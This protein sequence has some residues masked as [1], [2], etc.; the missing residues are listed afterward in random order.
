MNRR[1]SHRSQL[2]SWWKRAKSTFQQSPN[3]FNV[4]RNFDSIFLNCSKKKQRLIFWLRK[5]QC[6]PHSN[7]K[8]FFSVGLSFLVFFINSFEPFTTLLCHPLHRSTHWGTDNLWTNDFYA[9]FFTVIRAETEKAHM[10]IEGV[11]IALNNKLVSTF[12]RCLWSKFKRYRK[13]SAIGKNYIQDWC[14][15]KTK[16]SEKSSREPGFNT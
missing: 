14:V 8:N 4:S 9:S 15:C 7:K 13:V 5:A 3:Y 2:L 1:N 11:K 12:F 10:Y 16:Q 6:L